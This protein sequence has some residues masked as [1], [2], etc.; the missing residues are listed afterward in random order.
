M[1]EGSPYTE[2]HLP[3]RTAQAENVSLG[4][5]QAL[6][7]GLDVSGQWWQ[8]FASEPLDQLIRQALATSPNVAA[9]Q[10]ALRQARE[11]L[12]ASAGSLEWPNLTGQVG[13]S[14]Q[15]AGARDFSVFTAGVNVGYT[16]DLFGSAKR[17]L[18]GLQAGVEYQQFQVEA[19]YLTLTANL[20]ATAIREA[21]LRAQLTATSEVLAAQMRQ[22]AVVE[23]Q[24]ALGAVPRSTLL[25]LRTS[26]AQTRAT[27]PPLEKSLAQNRHLLAVLAGRLPQTAGLPEFHLEAFSLPGT[28]PVSLPSALV[29]QRPDIRASEALLHQASA[30]V[31]VST[32]NL[33]P[34]LTLSASLGGSAGQWD[35]LFT[36]PAQ[37]WSLGSSLTAPLFNGG[38]L[39]ARRRAAEA[40]YDQ[41]FAQ[42]RQT[43]LTSFQNVADTLRAIESDALALQAA[44]TAEAVARESLALTERQYKLGALSV[45]SLLDAERAHRQTRLALVQAQAARLTDTAVL[46]QALGGGW[47]LRGAL[48]DISRPATATASAPAAAAAVATP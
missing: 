13:A 21:S 2:G 26:L 38:A 37:V 32:A 29:R 17:Q 45:L 9:V 34:Q 27:V 19:T 11:N 22:L 31:G 8:L 23:Q 28:L 47:W 33:Y 25:A 41:A 42:Y 48:P 14:R 6:A 16:F 15:R 10:A 24:W 3:A 36:T 46:F 5:A 39:Q 35:K 40:A 7:V 18:E 4:E 12:A 20:A 43:V 44:A 30:Q 1:A